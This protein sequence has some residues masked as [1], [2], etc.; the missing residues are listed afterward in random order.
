MK[1][2]D[3]YPHRLP[4]DT[5][6]H[7]ERVGARRVVQD[8][9]RQ[10][11]EYTVGFRGPVPAFGPMPLRILWMDMERLAESAK[12]VRLP[13]ERPSDRFGREGK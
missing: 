7:G 8:P 1:L 12:V 3:D 6:I 4:E 11:V 9:A 13:D 5:R 2:Y 10:V